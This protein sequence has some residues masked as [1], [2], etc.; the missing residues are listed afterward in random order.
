MKESQKIGN[1]GGFTLVELIVTIAV[2]A[3]LA[4]VAVPSMSSFLDKRKV[5]SAAEELYSNIQ[6]ARSE[7]ITRNQTVGLRFSE[8]NTTTWAY[9]LS[10]STTCNPNEDL[11]A[12]GT[13]TPC[14]LVV[15]DGDG[16]IDD[17]TGT[18]DASDVV[19]YRFSSDDHPNVTMDMTTLPNL[20]KQIVFD[21]SRGTTNNTLDTVLLLTSETGYKMKVKVTPMGQVRICSP[22]GAGY[23]P[24]YSS[25]GC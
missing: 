20:N 21:P 24:G 2:I 23:V 17:G 16:V 14:I 12:L 4:T 25:N 22:A 3:I 19:L 9:G 1:S 15:D 7:A 6:Q 10:T 18:I 8:N 5:V 13:G 11:T